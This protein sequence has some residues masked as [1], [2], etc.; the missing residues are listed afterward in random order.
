MYIVQLML[1]TNFCTTKKK[2]HAVAINPILK[3]SA[4]TTKELQEG[5]VIS[6]KLSNT[7]S[8]RMLWY[9]EGV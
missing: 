6:K 9:N 7:S 8:K 2:T 1:R 5:I 4:I 3:V